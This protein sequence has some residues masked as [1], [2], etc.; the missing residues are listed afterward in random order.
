VT[1]EDPPA[2]EYIEAEE[3]EYSDKE[4]EIDT[5]R[6]KQIYVKR[7]SRKRYEV[8]VYKVW[9]KD[10][11]EAGLGEWSN[12]VEVKRELDHTDIYASVGAIIYTRDIPATPIP[13]ATSTPAP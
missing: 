8:A 1:T 3:G 9:Y 10:S 7:N 4:W 2:A 5:A 6:N 11:A 12:G 13:E